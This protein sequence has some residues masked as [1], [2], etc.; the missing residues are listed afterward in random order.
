M[1]NAIPSRGWFSPITLVDS[2]V[3]IAIPIPG[4]PL[5]RVW[6]VPLLLEDDDTDEEED[7]VAGG[8]IPDDDGWI[9]LEQKEPADGKETP[10]RKPRRRSP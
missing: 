4:P 5:M 7:D 10:K 9:H 3:V 1:P 2:D 6:R 8:G